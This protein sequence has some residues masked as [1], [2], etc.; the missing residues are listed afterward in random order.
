M[1]YWWLLLSIACC[2]LAIC[3]HVAAKTKSVQ[4]NR[5][6]R[7]LLEGGLI[8]L[9]ILLFFVALSSARKYLSD[10]SW[11]D[12]SPA[13]EIIL[14]A[15]MGL[16]MLARM[17]SLAIEDRSA[18]RAKMKLNQ[19]VPNIHLDGWDLLYPFLSSSICFGALV[20]TVE[21]MTMS[22]A[23]LVLAFQN[24][25]FWQTVLGAIRSKA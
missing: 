8:L 20:E 10:D 16:G 4:I 23:V 25:F 22:I 24:G 13:R 9:A 5:A 7:F 17:L 6:L 14:F 18:R 21:S 12:V 11:Y 2:L 15:F 1:T 19:E 3:T